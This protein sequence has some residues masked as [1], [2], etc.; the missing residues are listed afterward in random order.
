MN[1]AKI[2]RWEFC[3]PAIL[4]FSLLFL[5]PVIL[6]FAYSFTN[7]NAIRISNETAR[8]VGLDNYKTIFQDP[9]LF[10]IVRRTIRFGLLTTVGKNGIGFVLALMFFK[11]LKS[12]YALR[13]LFFLPAMLAPLVIG[14]MFGSIF[15]TTG[16]LN[17]L[18]EVLGLS[19]LTK[20]WLVHTA[21]TAFRTVVF[22]E[23]WRQAGFN[24][25]IYLAGLQLIDMNLFEAASIDGAGYFQQLFYIVLPRMI[26]AFSINLILNLS[27]G[28]KAFDI[29]QVLTIGGPAGGTEVINT[30]VYKMYGERLYGLS[31]AYSVVMFVIT[32]LF[33]FLALYL[34][35]RDVDT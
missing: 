4:L 26:T 9:E 27:V 18:L 14:L 32:A 5:A 11:G 24:M 21:K 34:T 1:D 7:W 35:T 13:A 16:A 15:E 6:G 12:L 29:I 22:V 19:H 28:L 33:G 31:S 3:L 2:Y 25:V 20:P 10:S 17:S 23:V 8:W 30:K